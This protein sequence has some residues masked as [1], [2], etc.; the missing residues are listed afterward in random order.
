[1][2]VKRK[3]AVTK[4]KRKIKSI[5]TVIDGITFDSRLES[6]CYTELR[7]AGMKFEMQVPYEIIPPFIYKGKKIRPMKWTPDFYI[8]SLNI[9]IETKGMANESFPLR[10]KMFMYMFTDGGNEPEVVILKNQKEIKEYV[11]KLKPKLS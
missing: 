5:K 7:D 11:A 8:P 10:L 1:M 3:K 6:C 9:L 4:D 2:I